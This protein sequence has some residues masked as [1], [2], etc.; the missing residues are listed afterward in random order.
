MQSVNFTDKEF[1]KIFGH[2]LPLFLDV[3]NEGDVVTHLTE[4]FLDRDKKRI[5]FSRNMKWF[6][7]H[8]GLSLASKWLDIAVNGKN[9]KFHRSQ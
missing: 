7:Q 3:K 9:S 5:E 8:N 6:N 2:P 1:N 4:F